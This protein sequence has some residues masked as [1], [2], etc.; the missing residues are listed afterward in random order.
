MPCTPFKL[1]TS[2]PPQR[3]H[4]PRQPQ[5]AQGRERD[6]LVQHLKARG[7]DFAQQGAVDAGHHEAGFL[8]AAV[9]RRQQGQGF[10]VQSVGAVGLELHQRGEAV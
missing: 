8:S 4:L 6:A 1:S 7:F 5:L 2:K 9:G 3:L 10:V